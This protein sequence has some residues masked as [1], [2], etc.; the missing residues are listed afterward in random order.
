MSFL[1]KILQNKRSEIEQAKKKRTL[2]Y[3]QESDSGKTPIS[4]KDSINAHRPAIVA[5][6]KRKSPSKGELRTIANPELLAKSYEQSGASG[7]SVLTDTN[8]FGGNLLDLQKIKQSVSIPILRKDFI[9]DPYQVVESRYYGADAILLISSCLSKDQL[10]ELIECAHENRLEVLIET[11]NEEDIAK[12]DDLVPDIVGV[13]NRNLRTFEQTIDNSFQL[14]N[15]LPS[16]SIKI[17][18]SALEN[19]DQLLELD[20]TGYDGFLIGETLMR[21]ENPGQQ[22]ESLIHRFR[23]NDATNTC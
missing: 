11:E 16:S 22:L 23:K 7:I 13:N 1:D 10:S 18:E 9:I 20:K 4:L 21:S 19:V 12:L 5:E 2:S 14:Y 8:F 3:F 17:S 6:I 15:S